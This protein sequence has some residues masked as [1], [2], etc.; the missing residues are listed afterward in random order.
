M[1]PVLIPVRRG[2]VRIETMAAI[3]GLGGALIILE[4]FWLAF[5]PFD[6]WTGLLAGA[7]VIAA[8]ALAQSRKALRP[9]LG[10]TIVL[11]GLGSLFSGGGFY[12]G[13]ILAIV[14]GALLASTRPLYRG[15]SPASSFADRLGPPCPKCGRHVPSWS[16]RC[17]YCGFPEEDAA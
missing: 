15:G 4:A 10:A 17:P 12:L 3:A 11:A 8:A 14:G 13:A 2:P 7:A 5:V 16:S 9:I 1:I 6:F